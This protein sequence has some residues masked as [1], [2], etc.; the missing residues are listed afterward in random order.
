MGVD[1]DPL[2][3]VDG[4]L[5]IILIEKL[6]VESKNENRRRKRI[7]AWKIPNSLDAPKSKYARSFLR[8]NI[9]IVCWL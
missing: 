1:R 4:D 3:P 9:F 5:R 2:D 7:W 8:E 6:V